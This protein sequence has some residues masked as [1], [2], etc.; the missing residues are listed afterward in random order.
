[1]RERLDR[2]WRVVATGLCFAMFGVGSL[3]LG[4]V[5]FPL[6]RLSVRDRARQVQLSRS[7]IRSTFRLFVGLMRATGV[8]SVEV[9]GRE[10]LRGGGRLILA[11]HPTLI[12]VVLLLALVDHGDC[13]IKGAL[14]RNPVTSAT[15]RAAGFVFNDDGGEDLVHDC[16]QSVRT[17]NN[18]IIFPEG[19]RSSPGLPLRL[20]RGAARVAVHGAVD[21]T[22]VRIRCVPATLAKGER[23]WAV[24]ARRAHIRIEVDEPIAVSPFIAASPNRAL[25]ARQLTEHLTDYFSRGHD[26]ASA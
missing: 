13:V 24:P 5:V 17:G 10:R 26:L 18:L 4:L 16:V 22:P 8:L 25:A 19:T 12:D 20:Q 9:L 14:G 15:V 11:N 1:M 6:L 23:W 3:V 7:L 2:P 21:I